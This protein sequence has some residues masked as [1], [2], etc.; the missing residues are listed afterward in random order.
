MS[1]RREAAVLVVSISLSAC[2]TT[3]TQTGAQALDENAGQK[4]A[5]QSVDEALALSSKKIEAML[6]D[7]QSLS[8]PVALPKSDKANDKITI[9]WSGEAVSLLKRLAEL[10]GYSFTE[11][12]KPTGPLLIY[13]NARAEPL[14][15]VLRNIGAQLGP[16]ADIVLKD[17]AVELVYH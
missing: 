16:R 6:T 11:T 3:A 12:G 10:R 5:Q 17:K 15:D 7:F 14:M 4:T 1:F 13:V 9:A 2:G 8:E